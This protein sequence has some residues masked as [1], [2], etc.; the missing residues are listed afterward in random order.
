MED[1]ITIYCFQQIYV[2]TLWQLRNDFLYI[3]RLK[4]GGRPS[5]FKSRIHFG[6]SCLKIVKQLL[7]WVRYISSHFFCVEAIHEL[8]SSCMYPFWLTSYRGFCFYF[9]VLNEIIFSIQQS[10]GV[11]C[12][13][14]R[15]YNC[16][17]NSS[18][19]VLVCLI[20]L[21]K[22]FSFFF[23]LFVFISYLW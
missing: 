1:G 11:N 10:S 13:Q 3:C 12:H 23:F 8:W 18:S 15:A 20:F 19:W 6:N 5:T 17:L 2:D 21:L 9:Y 16:R 14:M 4:T 7:K 22:R